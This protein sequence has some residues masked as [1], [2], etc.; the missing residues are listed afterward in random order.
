MIEKAVA[1]GWQRQVEMNEQIKT[2]LE[3]IILGLES[4]EAPQ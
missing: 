4:D 3:N 1:N 2:N